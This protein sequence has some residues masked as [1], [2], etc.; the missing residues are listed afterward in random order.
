[1]ISRIKKHSGRL[2]LAIIG[3]LLISGN[4]RAQIVVVNTGSLVSLTADDP[5]NAVL[6]FE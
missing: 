3:L 4:E 1:M 5:K 6:S 2:V